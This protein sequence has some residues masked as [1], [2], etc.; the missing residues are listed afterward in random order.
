MPSQTQRQAYCQT[1]R[2]GERDETPQGENTVR[3]IG[4][5]RVKLRQR[6][7]N[8][9]III[10]LPGARKF[11]QFTGSLSLTFQNCFNSEKQISDYLCACACDFQ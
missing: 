9:K 2:H 4:L 3:Q 10:L 1:H 11:Y 8:T 6:M 5:E 7:K